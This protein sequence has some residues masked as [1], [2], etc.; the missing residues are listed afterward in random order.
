ML[1]KKERKETEHGHLAAKSGNRMKQVPKPAPP[2]NNALAA[3]TK[4]TKHRSN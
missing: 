2:N 3:S 1:K 4:S